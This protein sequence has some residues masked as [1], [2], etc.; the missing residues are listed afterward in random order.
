MQIWPPGNFLFGQGFIEINDIMQTHAT[1]C[2]I[3][4]RFSI[5]GCKVMAH[6]NFKHLYEKRQSG[7]T[8]LAFM[9]FPK[10]ECLWLL[11]K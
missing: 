6:W 4:Q 1:K 2:I 11:L 9:F 10:F 7:L 8:S 3:I 5:N